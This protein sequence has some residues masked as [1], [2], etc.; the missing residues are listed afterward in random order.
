MN[1]FRSNMTTEKSTESEE[2]TS[3]SSL[4]AATA[5]QTSGVFTQACEYS[6]QK[7]KR[8]HR[9]RRKHVE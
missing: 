1:I 2:K 8:L 6:F 9:D 5:K 3:S 7:Q 4:A